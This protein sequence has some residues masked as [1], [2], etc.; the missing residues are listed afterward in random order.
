MNWC[1]HAN[2]LQSSAI[3]L[4][5]TCCM[6][7]K[8]RN[9]L[10]LC[11]LPMR[12]FPS[13]LLICDIQRKALINL[14]TL[15]FGRVTVRYAKVSMLQHYT[16]NNDKKCFQSRLVKGTFTLSVCV[17]ACDVAISEMRSMFPLPPSSKRDLKTVRSGKCRETQWELACG[18]LFTM[19]EVRTCNSVQHCRFRI[20]VHTHR[21]RNIFCRFFLWW[22]FFAYAWCQWTLFTLSIWYCDCSTLIL[23][24]ELHHDNVLD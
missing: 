15:G 4:T 9:N 11:L 13:N 7:C 14:R 24:C 1:S 2:K 18:T 19:S 23:M 20:K 3:I 22:F 21:K 17:T 8:L 6:L 12:I 5:F 16:E 10:S